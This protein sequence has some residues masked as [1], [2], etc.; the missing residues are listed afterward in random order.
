M[1]GV[2]Y[3]RCCRVKSEFSVAVNGLPELPTLSTPPWEAVM[4]RTAAFSPYF[5]GM[6][7]FAVVLSTFRKIPSGPAVPVML[8]FIPLAAPQYPPVT[9]V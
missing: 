8:P 3:S 6:R 9:K 2:W 5:R 4:F 7:F 1:L